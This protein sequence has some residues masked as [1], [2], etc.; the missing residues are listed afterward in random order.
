MNNVT[1]AYKTPNKLRSGF[2]GAPGSY[3]NPLPGGAY[4]D[5]NTMEAVNEAEQCA[6][7]HF[8]QQ[9]ENE[10]LPNLK[11]ISGGLQVCGR[12]NAPELISV[13]WQ[14]H[15]TA[16]AMLIAPNLLHV[17]GD[18]VVEK[19]G[20]VDCGLAELYIRDNFSPASN[21]VS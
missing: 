4:M 1:F 21:Y 8:C 10:R 6:G 16:D 19:G 3:G 7:N 13:G 18:F 20:V 2:Q 12:M 15:V 5:Y 9:H 17:G 14:I 11:S